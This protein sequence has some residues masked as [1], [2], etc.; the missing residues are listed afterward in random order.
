GL[1]WLLFLQRFGFGGCLADDMGLGKTVQVLALLESRRE[2]RAK[3]ARKNGDAQGPGPS[4][5]VVPKSLVF[6]W[7]QEAA[8]FAPQLRVLDHT[9]TDRLK[10][11][12]HFNDYDL[13]ITTYG[14]LRRDAVHFKDVSFDYC[15]L[16]E[17]QAIKNARTEAAKAVR[18]L[19]GNHRLA[20][21]G[22]P[23]EN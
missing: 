15:I 20:L 4:L 18:L 22:T 14:T 7:K 3:H 23:I 16:D 2:L 17:S 1:G 19:Q 8:R 6:N 12:E 10:P 9:G 5:V 21:S 11:G 13:I